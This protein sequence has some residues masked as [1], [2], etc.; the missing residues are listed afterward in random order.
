LRELKAHSKARNACAAVAKAMKRTERAV[1]ATTASVSVTVADGFSTVGIANCRV[2]PQ[3][4]AQKLSCSPIG[5][6]GASQIAW[7]ASLR[8][9]T[10]LWP[11]DTFHYA[12]TLDMPVE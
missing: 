12:I 10:D 7:R 11:L 4:T 9:E 3:Q 6:S 1:R 5:R 8:P 2:C